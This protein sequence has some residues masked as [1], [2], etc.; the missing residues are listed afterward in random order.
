MNDVCVSRTGNVFSIASSEFKA[1]FPD[2]TSIVFWSP[3]WH[4][5]SVDEEDRRALEFARGEWDRKNVVK[6][7]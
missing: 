7:N 4:E 2:G 3:P 6:Q 1:E 5:W